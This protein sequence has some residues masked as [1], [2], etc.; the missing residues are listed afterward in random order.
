MTKTL[1]RRVL[2]GG[3]AATAPVVVACYAGG[4]PAGQPPATG[5]KEMTLTWQVEMQAPELARVPEFLTEWSQRY[6]KVK[7][8]A[9]HFGG[10]D[11]EK[12]EKMLT[13][14]AAGSPVDVVGKLTFLQPLAS[15]GGLQAIDALVKR[16]KFDL[17]KQNKNW[18]ND[19]DSYQG[20]L[21]GLPYGMG[22]SA[23]VFVYNRS[24]FQQEGLKEPSAD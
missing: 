19:F 23:M 21:Y 11:G 22:G 8:E 12:I 24:H 4:T 5:A 1:R 17:S 10:G 6:P 15:P 7:V 20:K 18:L 14:A 9:Q 16:D 2:L 13:M 3:I